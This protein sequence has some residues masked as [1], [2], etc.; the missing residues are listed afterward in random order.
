MKPRSLFL[1][2]F[3]IKIR[4]YKYIKKYLNQSFLSIYKINTKVEITGYKTVNLFE[5]G[6]FMVF[7]F[8]IN[9]FLNSINDFRPIFDFIIPIVKVIILYLLNNKSVFF[10]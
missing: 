9:K 6:I 4:Y 3:I 10:N 5:L 2:S 7:E 8:V 1:N